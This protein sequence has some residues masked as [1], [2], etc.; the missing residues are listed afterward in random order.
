[1]FYINGMQINR[2]LNFTDKGH[3]MQT[4]R[5]RSFT[6]NQHLFYINGMQTNRWQNFTHEGH[7]FYIKPPWYANKQIAK[8]YNR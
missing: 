2:W 6:D 1:M 8:F 7:L 5:L 3:L 4:Y